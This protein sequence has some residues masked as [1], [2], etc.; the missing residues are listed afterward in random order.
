MSGRQSKRRRRFKN[1]SNELWAP[2]VPEN[3]VP[4][5]SPKISVQF[6]LRI[7]PNVRIPPLF[8]MVFEKSFIFAPQARKFL[9]KMNSIVKK[10]G[11]S[12]F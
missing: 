6:H 12:H 2:Q 7:P 5:Y 1:K 8:S 10:S 9:A 11:K 4:K 3:I